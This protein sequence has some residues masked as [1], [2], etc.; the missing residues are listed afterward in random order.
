MGVTRPVHSGRGADNI[1]QP[2]G[3]ELSALAL[4][5][6]FLLAMLAEGVYAAVTGVRSL[7][8]TVL[9]SLES[10]VF[11][12]RFLAGLQ[13]KNIELCRQIAMDGFPMVTVNRVAGAL[14]ALFCLA[15]LVAAGVIILTGLSSG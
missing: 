13:E 9:G 10:R 7:F 4:M 14:V 8:L 15:F 5:A 11:R 2:G 3:L 6:A 1:Y 12:T